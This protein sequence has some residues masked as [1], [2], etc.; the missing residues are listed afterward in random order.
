DAR[1]V[2]ELA[3]PGESL[4]TFLAKNSGDYRPGDT[5]SKDPLSPKAAM[6]QTL[7]RRTD[8]KDG[9]LPVVKPD[10][11]FADGTNELWDDGK[12][13]D[14]GERD[15][16]FSN[17]YAQLDQEGTYSWR[18]FIEGRTPKG[19][20]FTRLLTRG[21]WVGIGVD[22]RATK[23]ELNYDVPRHSDLS[24]VQIIVLPVDRRGQLL[25]P[26]H[27]SDVKITANGGQFQGSDK[28]TPVTN[29][30]VVYPQPDKGDL[31]SHY[32]GRYSR[33]LLFRPGEKIEV[34]ITIQGM[35]LDPIIVS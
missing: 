26:F 29:D 18:F 25:G 11:F 34:Q 7:I 24:A 6:L 10:K 21:I 28:Q 35:K 16:V 8:Q 2:V 17:T 4:G 12:H 33:I 15:G 32:D 1:V 30:G 20:Y 19:G 22:P 31:I 23:V 9:Q 5:D 3:R 13:R 14:G 27:P